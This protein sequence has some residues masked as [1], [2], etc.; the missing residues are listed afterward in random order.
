MTRLTKT[1]PV[2]LVPEQLLVTTVG[3]D[4]IHLGGRSQLALP[5][6]L[7][8]QGMS[9]KVG[10]TGHPP[11]VVIAAGS[12][13]T[14]TLLVCTPVLLTVLSVRQVRAAGN[15][16]RMAG[17]IW[18]KDHPFLLAMNTCNR[19]VPVKK[20]ALIAKAQANLHP[21]SPSKRL[22]HRLNGRS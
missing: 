17:F 10:F 3:L 1:L 5:F 12:R 21:P 6:T 11:S 15:G 22:G 16:A 18:H 7:G 2:S 13:R 20:A 14:A 19:N 9:A 8:A 4:M